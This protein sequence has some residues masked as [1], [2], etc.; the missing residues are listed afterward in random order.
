MITCIFIYKLYV[1]N[2]SVFYVFIFTCISVLIGYQDFFYASFIFIFSTPLIIFRFLFQ[3]KKPFFVLVI[4]ILLGYLIFNYVQFSIKDKENIFNSGFIYKDKTEIDTKVKL[5]TFPNYKYSNNQYVFHVENSKTNILVFT[6]FFQKFPYLTELN[7]SGKFND[8]RNE[9][10]VWQKYYKKLNVQ[11]IVWNPKIIEINNLKPKTLKEKIMLKLFSFKIFVREKSLERFS[12]YTSSLILGM[13]LGEKD[14]L[15]KEEK[16]IF[17][18]SN[19]SHI[20]VVSGYNISLIILFIFIIL[21]NFNRYIKV[22]FAS[23]FIFLFVL[24]V[25]F[26]ASVIRASMM[27]VI[28]IFSRIFHR[29][30]NGINALLSVSCIMILINPFSIFDIGFHLSFLATFSLIVYRKIKY[31]PEY[32]GTTIWVFIFISFYILYLSDSIS[33]YGILSNILVLL[34]IPIFMLISFVGLILNICHV[35]IGVDTLVLEIMSRYIFGVARVTSSLPRIELKVSPNFTFIIYLFTLSVIIF[36][37]NRYTTI[38]FIEKHYQK[39]VP[40][41][42]S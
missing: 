13:F 38:E 12:P 4:F 9:D 1:V 36:L 16:Q 28:L 10:L 41:K 26:D 20:L 14:E 19:L 21:R 27:G 6:E 31:I 33:L 2:L 17:N 18:N 3:V 24:L 29:S 32:V 37:N 22:I 5:E 11:Y 40:Q 30:N 8:I 39:F 15:S 42:P 35:F 7:L 34:I 23:V 25:G